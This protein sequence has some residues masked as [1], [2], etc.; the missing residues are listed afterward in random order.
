M[1]RLL[2]LAIQALARQFFHP[3]ELSENQWL[4]SYTQHFDTV[5]ITNTFYRLPD[6]PTLPPTWPYNVRLWRRPN[7]LLD[8]CGA[9][10]P[11]PAHAGSSSG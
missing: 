7:G 3:A 6:T 5:E 4:D 1:Y 10:S 8:G 11:L 9:S 2:G